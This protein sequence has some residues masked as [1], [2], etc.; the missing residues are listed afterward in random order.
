MPTKVTRGLMYGW[1]CNDNNDDG[2]RSVACCKE[3]GITRELR[4]CKLK[5]TL[6]VDL[7]KLMRETIYKMATVMSCG[8]R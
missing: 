2:A 1:I 4:T 7:L 3:N 6:V 5:W 8:I